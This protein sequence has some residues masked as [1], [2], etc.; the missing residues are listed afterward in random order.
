M[1]EIRVTRAADLDERTSQSKGMVRKAAI[2]GEMS[3]AQ[4][5]CA[6]VMVAE[7]HS[8]S[9]VHHHGEQETIVYALSGW[10]GVR[11]G[12]GGK[13]LVELHA[14]DFALIPAG[15]VHQEVNLGDEE[16]TWV[17]TRSGTEPMVV[18]LEGFPGR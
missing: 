5:I 2:T 14:G 13:D 6:S 4:K 12:A 18:N 3:G 15:V 11:S 10:S 17:V 8:E 7:P 16:V 9:S 1:S